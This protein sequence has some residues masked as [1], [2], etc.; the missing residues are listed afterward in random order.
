[1]LVSL[2]PEKTNMKKDEK[3]INKKHINISH[4]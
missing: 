1:M 3:K 4:K 2:I